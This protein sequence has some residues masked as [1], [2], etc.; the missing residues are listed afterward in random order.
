MIEGPLEP[1]TS[2]ELGDKAIKLR[3][4]VLPPGIFRHL[5]RGATQ[6]VPVLRR[7]G[8][9]RDRLPA[10][11]R[12]E[13]APVHHLRGFGTEEVRFLDEPA[14]RLS[15]LADLIEPREAFDSYPIRRV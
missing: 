11:R 13:R 2:T 1:Y 9:G 3:S 12:A 15:F 7:D 10:R 6:K 4:V 5:V 8:K 14:D